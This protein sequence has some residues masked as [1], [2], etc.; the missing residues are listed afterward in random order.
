EADKTMA[1]LVTRLLTA[2]CEKQTRE[3]ASLE[4]NM[5]M[6]NAFRALGEVAM[7]EL[8]GSPEVAASVGGGEDA[9]ADDDDDGYF[10]RFQSLP[11]RHADRE[12]AG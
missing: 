2:N 11:Q 9:D 7:R 8:M 5:G 1:A 3:V 4:G 10:F 6:Y 12:A